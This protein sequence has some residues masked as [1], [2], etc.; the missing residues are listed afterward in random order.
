MQKQ[1]EKIKKEN[2]DL[3][4]E[5]TQMNLKTNE[6]KTL[7]QE[8]EAQVDVISDHIASLT[9]EAD[10]L[11]YELEM[12]KNSDASLANIQKFK[13]SSKNLATEKQRLLDEIELLRKRNNMLTAQLERRRK[14]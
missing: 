3:M 5:I 11:K 1:I 8:A 12:A 7:I 4:V 2:G 10:K 9:E 14:D 13:K 6:R